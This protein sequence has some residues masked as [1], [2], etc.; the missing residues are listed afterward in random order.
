[1]TNNLIWKKVRIF[2][3]FI[4][5]VVFF[6]ACQKEKGK[7][8]LEIKELQ[9]QLEKTPEDLGLIR[10]YV[11]STLSQ[12]RNIQKGK[13]KKLLE[14]IK[15]KA[16]E[17]LAQRDD[18]YMRLTLAQIKFQL[19]SVSNRDRRVI[20]A[21]KYIQE[22]TDIFTEL[23][24]KYPDDVIIRMYR[25]INY[26]NLPGIFQRKKD[27]NVDINFVYDWVRTTDLDSID[28]VTK[29][30]ILGVAMSGRSVVKELTQKEKIEKIIEKL[31]L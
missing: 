6:V 18:K 25:F 3:I 30:E 28:V 16:E 5:V 27:I 2:F 15:E 21:V 7:V 17:Y 13:N 22:G 4:A 23:V 1:M 31:Q 19:A 20:A 9:K 14:D 11:N 29:T 10:E 8:S 26:I 24:G 12:Q